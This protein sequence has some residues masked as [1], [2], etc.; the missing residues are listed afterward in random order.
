MIGLI[1]VG[2]RNGLLSPW[3]AFPSIFGERQWKVVLD[4]DLNDR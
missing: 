1:S 4:N 2:Y 3:S